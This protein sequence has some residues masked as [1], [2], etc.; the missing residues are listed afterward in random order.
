MQQVLLLG[1]LTIQEVLERNVGRKDHRHLLTLPGVIRCIFLGTILYFSLPPAIVVREPDQVMVSC[2]K[3]E[4]L[5]DLKGLFIA[6]RIVTALLISTF[7]R[8][9][10][11]FLL[12]R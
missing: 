5:G 9:G 12:P 1:G 6:L 3:D 2:R 7:F 4:I 10:Q 8:R 11:Y